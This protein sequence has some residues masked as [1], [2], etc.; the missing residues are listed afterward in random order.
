MQQAKDSSKRLEQQVTEVMPP[1]LAG[2]VTGF[3]ALPVAFPLFASGKAVE[4]QAHC[5]PLLCRLRLDPEFAEAVCAAIMEAAEQAVARVTPAS[6][7]DVGEIA[8]RA[9]VLK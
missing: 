6:M 7:T 9:K 1:A 8:R 3:S 2:V 5:G 4:L